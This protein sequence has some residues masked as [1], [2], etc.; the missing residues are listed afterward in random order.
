MDS[1]NKIETHHGEFMNTV[2]K[3]FVKLWLAIGNL[4][5]ILVPNKKVDGLKEI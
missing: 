3:Y 5:F 1:E 4:A 2:Q